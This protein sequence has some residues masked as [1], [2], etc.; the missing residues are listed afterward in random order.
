MKVI[1]I[2]QNWNPRLQKSLE[3]TSALLTQQIVRQPDVPSIFHSEFDNFDLLFNT[4]SG[5]DSFHTAHGI[6]V[7]EV[8]SDNTGEHEG[9]KPVAPSLPR[10]LP[11]STSPARAA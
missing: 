8:L 11:K 9:I 10:A 4:M 3:Q 5:T 6:M 2:Q 1:H 7:Q